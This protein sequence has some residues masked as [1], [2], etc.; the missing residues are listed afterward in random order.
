[1]L[2]LVL[3][4]V[5]VVLAMLIGMTSG[6]YLYQTVMDGRLPPWFGVA[7]GFGIAIT[8]I[9]AEQ[10]FRR[11]FARSVVAFLI[12]LGGGVT[13]SI[14]LLSVLSLVIQDRDLYNNL[15]LP[16]ALVTTYLVMITVLRNIDRWRVVIPFVEFR[17]EQSQGGAL[18]VDAD[19]LADTRLPGLLK[20]GLFAERVMV[21]RRVL[22]RIE[23][24]SHAG[25]PAEQARATRALEGLKELRTLTMPR[26]E[27]DETEVPNAANLDDLLV[28]LCRLENARLIAGDR[29]LQRRAEAEAVPVIDLAALAGLLIPTIKP[30]EIIQV[31]IDR[32]GEGKG[33]GVGFLQDGSMVIVNGGAEHLGKTVRATVMR[34]HATA[35]GRMVFTELLTA[36][37]A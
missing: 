24:L 10:A 21:H 28:R 14:L 1:M 20:T 30:G 11:R 8:L 15:D 18:V 12:G 13:L 4:I 9:A 17:S 3:R 35:N 33:Q 31:P 27:I 26:V 6:K 36:G 34:T 2:I 5:F 16:V 22:S 23:E 37:A 25:N 32:P 19:I 29:D 7:M